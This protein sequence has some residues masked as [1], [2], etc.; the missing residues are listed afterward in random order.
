MPDKIYI[1]IARTGSF[2]SHH[3]WVHSIHNNLQ[4]ANEYRD[5]VNKLME[6]K[7]RVPCP[8]P[9]DEDGDLINEED[10]N[11]VQRAEYN[12]WYVNYLPARGWN[13]AIIEEYEI[14]EISFDPLTA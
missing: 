7:K 4:R 1:V 3:T 6:D 2:S 9:V 5:A 14:D 12:E 13:G 11:Q 10:L 8:F